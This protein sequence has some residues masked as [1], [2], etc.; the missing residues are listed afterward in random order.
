MQLAQTHDQTIHVTTS[1]SQPHH[2]KG[3]TRPVVRARDSA[4]GRWLLRGVPAFAISVLVGATVTD[5]VWTA[6]PQKLSV[7]TNI[8][9]S[10]TF[11]DFN[12]FRYHDA[13][14]LL[15]FVF[16]LATTVVFLALT[17]LGPLTY[18][19][20]NLRPW[21]PHLGS[22]PLDRIPDPPGT[23]IG[24]VL[25]L[26]VP[27]AILGFEIA[28]ARSS[29]SGA[30][31]APGILAG[32]VYLI[33]I[34]SIAMAWSGVTKASAGKV[35]GGYLLSQTLDRLA[36]TNAI[37]STG[38]IL[39]VYFVSQ[40]TALT[41]ES[42]HRTVSY[43]WL[44]LWLDLL[45]ILVCA[46]LIWGIVQKTSISW[47]RAEAGAIAVLGGSTLLYLITAN[48]TPVL[49]AFSG[50]DDSHY[51]VGAQLTFQR[52]LTLWRDLYLL[53]GPLYD[54]LYGILGIHVFGHGRWGAANG[55]SLIVSPL[56]A[57]SVFTFAAYFLRRRYLALAGI[58]LALVLGTLPSMEPR[59]ILLPPLVILFDRVIRT[60]SNLLCAAFASLTLVE[61]ILTPETALLAVSLFGTLLVCEL[62]HRA[63]GAPVFV[64]FYRT[65][66]CIG[67][68]VLAGLIWMAILLWM[69][70]LSGFI[71]YFLTA[72][73]GHS[74]EGAFKYPGLGTDIAATA[75]L[76]ISPILIVMTYWRG[77]HKLLT[78]SAWSSR[79]W[80]LIACAGMAALY[81]TKGLDRI[82]VYHVY[83]VFAASLPLLIIWVGII[84]DKG[85]D[86]LRSHVSG[87]LVGRPFSLIALM[88]VGLSSPLGIGTIATATAHYKGTAPTNP[89]ASQPKLGYTYP[90]DV[91][92]A[93]IND[94]KAVLDRYAGPNGPVYDFSN[95]AGVTNYLLNRLPGTRFYDPALA[96]TSLA[97]TLL[98]ND[99]KKSR[100][101]VIIFYNRT[102]GLFNYDGI[103][104]MVREYLA[105]Q[106]ILDHYSPLLDT[107]GQLI[108]L[109]NDLLASA[110]LPPHLS[111]PPLTTGLY[112][113]MPSCDWGDIPNFFA[114]P[115]EVREGRGSVQLSVG[116]PRQVE[117]VS[118]TGWA[119]ASGT[120]PVQSVLVV[121]NGRVVASA[122][123]NLLRP[124][125]AS[126]LADPL[127]LHSGF[128]ETFSLPKN[129]KWSL[130]AQTASK[131]L[132]SLSSAS[133]SRTSGLA[134]HVDDISQK[135][136]TS[137]R[138]QIPSGRSWTDFQWLA[139]RSVQDFGSRNISIGD[140]SG[141]TSHTI[142]LESL[143]R[144]RNALFLRVGSCLQWHGFDSSQLV[145]NM[146][147]PA[148]ALSVAA[149]NSSR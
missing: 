64:A 38:L 145:I 7:T 118:V 10:T 106:Y 87:P 112:F 28:V 68:G 33:A 134:G 147:G 77:A 105:G 50:F 78:R 93:Q 26:C 27:A 83:E 96:Q 55:M 18:S 2:D 131:R 117:D 60:R 127:A 121:S 116:P 71:D 90:G 115:Q 57:V 86:F 13:Y 32:I 36:T 15:T 35:R 74:L 128:L 39:G 138:L 135:I 3:P 100:P 65:T 107:H 75:E 37:G 61:V 132:V 46:L 16:P 5:L 129:A 98:I 41:V 40:S 8:V 119:F 72:A 47:R 51:L 44:P 140:G 149:V 111:A 73:P 92:L 48:L 109:R 97:Q 52:G 1:V 144:A 133:A 62:V 136:Q 70:A 22:Q 89:P 139:I 95:D 103:T 79:D 88:L 142:T 113:D 31:V 25:R 82:D 34:P 53:H 54:D 125:V 130:F 148:A 30:G 63:K 4:P 14:Y 9:G 20:R 67:W 49:G 101:P 19:R 24:A 104:S 102:F 42:A 108:F 11:D 137:Y 141:Q 81:Y 84:I 43:P 80:V 94:L 76:L 29:R 146:S 66:R 58:G 59:F 12:V 85:D 114:V 21:P 56:A 124:D 6:V 126:H 17:R 23:A 120:D 45:L 91:D 110:P 122:P 143:P 69:G 99:L 123:T